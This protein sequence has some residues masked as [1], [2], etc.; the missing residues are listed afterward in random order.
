[1]KKE[2]DVFKGYFFVSCKVSDT[3]LDAKS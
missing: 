2:L 3:Y 1:M